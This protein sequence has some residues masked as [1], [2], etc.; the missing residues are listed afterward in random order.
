MKIGTFLLGFLLLCTAAVSGSA[1]ADRYGRGRGHYG[2]GYYGHGPRVGVVVGI[3]FGYPWYGYGMPPYYAPYNNYPP[4]YYPRQVIVQPEPQVYIERAAP[5]AAP[6]AQAYW[7]YCSN[8]QGYYPYVKE[9]PAGWQQ[10]MPTPPP[11]N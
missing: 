6:Q 1:W 7:H 2:H 5:Q 3:P 9:C 10:V 4:Y 11:S 8:P